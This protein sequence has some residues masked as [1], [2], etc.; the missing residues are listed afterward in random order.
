MT[1]QP[2]ATRV[3]STREALLDAA[4][5]L[6]EREGLDG[7]T[8]RALGTAAGV[9]RGAPYRHFADKD[10]LLAA[11]A[12]RGMRDLRLA[13]TAAGQKG[14]VSGSGTGRIGASTSR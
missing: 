13:V 11:I 3:L 14:A 9:S 10:D 7:V 2:T 6:L 4:A 1:Q 8:L 5:A 12:T